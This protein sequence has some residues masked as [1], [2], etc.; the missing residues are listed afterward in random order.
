MCIEDA[1]TKYAITLVD[2]AKYADYEGDIGD[3]IPEYKDLDLDGDH[4]SDVIKREGHHYVFELTRKGTF[5][6]DDYSVSPN[7]REVI[8]FEDLGC[9]AISAS[10]L[11]KAIF[12]IWGLIIPIWEPWKMLMEHHGIPSLMQTEKCTGIMHL[13]L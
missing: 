6:S 2:G 9:R 12:M 10:F 1:V 7:E 11:M 4:K 13:P 5:E 3:V 8:Q